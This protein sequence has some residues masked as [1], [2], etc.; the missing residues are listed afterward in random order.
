MEV[1]R[2]SGRRVV[3]PRTLNCTLHPAY[4]AYALDATVG[5]HCTV[6]YFASAHIL[7]RHHGDYFA[8]SSYAS[9]ANFPSAGLEVPRS[10]RPSREPALQ[11]L[12]RVRSIVSQD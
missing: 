9:H 1:A 2:L 11:E 4:R 10:P 6:D 5:E 12:G 3:L 8:E 7:Q